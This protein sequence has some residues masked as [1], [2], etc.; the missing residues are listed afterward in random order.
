MMHQAGLDG[1]ARE[2]HAQRGQ[3]EFV[4]HRAIQ[5]PADRAAR[6]RVQ[7]HGE[8]D[9]LVAQPDVGDIGAPQLIDR[10]PLRSNWALSW[11]RERGRWKCWS[12]IALKR[13]RPK[14]E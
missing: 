14:T 1:A 8:E 2:R 5:R 12:L 6:V 4:F 10:G 13:L 11:Y 3:R 7:N 9:E